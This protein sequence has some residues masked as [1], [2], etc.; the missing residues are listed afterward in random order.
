MQFQDSDIEK[1]AS[2]SRLKLSQS[3]I[4]RF[5]DQL[6]SVLTYVEQIS[7]ISAK[8]NMQRGQE[9]GNF[10]ADVS[11]QSEATKEELLAQAPKVEEGHISVLTVK[12]HGMDDHT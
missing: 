1:L 10:R 5:R 8:P 3:K 6:S 9:S 2:L 4:E 7:K 12:T 11:Q